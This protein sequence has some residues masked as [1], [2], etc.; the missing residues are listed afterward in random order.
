MA[1]N[2]LKRSGYSRRSRN[3]RMSYV[4]AYW[5][6]APDGKKKTRQRCRECGAE[7]IRVSM[8]NGGSAT[9]EAAPGLSRV[10][11]PCAHRGEGLSRRRDD[12]IQDL[13]EYFDFD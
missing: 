13:F 11:H 8:A 7:I 12:E 2:L 6:S 5:A 10:K 9:F 3:G 4:N 1:R